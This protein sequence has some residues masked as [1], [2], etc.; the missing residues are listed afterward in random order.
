MIMRGIRVKYEALSELSYYR[1]AT[2]EQTR[3]WGQPKDI[4]D[5]AD[6][7]RSSF[8]SGIMVLDHRLGVAFHFVPFDGPCLFDLSLAQSHAAA[9]PTC[10]VLARFSIDKT[11]ITFAR[12]EVKRD[13]GRIH[14][15][16]SFMN[17]LILVHAVNGPLHDMSRGEPQ[18]LES[19]VCE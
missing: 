9:Y 8:P 18:S 11:C 15:P 2:P 12:V 16:T 6:R 10:L 17:D 14:A 13:S 7:L 1:V 4:Q 3:W 19:D 5:L